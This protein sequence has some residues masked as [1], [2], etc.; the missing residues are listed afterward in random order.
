MVIVPFYGSKCIPLNLLKRGKFVAL[1]LQLQFPFSKYIEFCTQYFWPQYTDQAIL[2]LLLW[3]LQF[4]NYLLREENLNSYDEL[5][6]ETPRPLVVD[7]KLDTWSG[8]QGEN[9]QQW[10]QVCGQKSTTLT[11]RSQSP[12]VLKWIHHLRSNEVYCHSV[13]V[14]KSLLMHN[15]TV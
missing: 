6:C 15:H 5:T 7:G 8:Y 10:C 2:F 14:M 12:L 13:E 4:W 11:T 1:M 3:Q 9:S